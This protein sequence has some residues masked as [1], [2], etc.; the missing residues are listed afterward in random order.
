MK[1]KIHCLVLFGMILFVIPARA[2]TVRRV[3]NNLAVSGINIYASLQDAHDA[4]DAGDIVYVEPSSQPYTGN[5]NCSKKLYIYGAGYLYNQNSDLTQNALPS[6]IS[7]LIYFYQ[8]SAGS[9]ISGLEVIGQIRIHDSNIKVYRNYLNWVSS[10]ISVDAYDNTN[11]HSISDILIIG[12]FLP[13][14]GMIYVTGQSYQSVVYSVSNVTISN[15]FIGLRFTANE[16]VSGIIYHH[17]LLGTGSNGATFVAY[18]TAIENNIFLGT[19]GNPFDQT[20]NAGLDNA[21]INCSLSN[22]I[23]VGTGIL[24]V[25]FG[26]QNGVLINNELTTTPHSDD[27]AFIL[28]ANSPLKTAA[29]DGGEVGMFGGPTPYILSG[30]PSRPS[31]QNLLSTATGSE[32]MPIKVSVTVK[33]NH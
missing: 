22:N 16:Y 13:E 9:E 26:N 23:A 1:S 12:N 17:N 19:L 7:G 4:A 27:G 24:P 11:F 29:T 3:D 10:T 2:Q 31:V 30:V 25:G 33:A 20:Y 21:A 32:T 6:K 14:N 15:N 8:G 5:L 28:K 18:N